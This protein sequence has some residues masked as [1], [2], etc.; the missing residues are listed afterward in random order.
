MGNKLYL[1]Y[2]KLINRGPRV[3]GRK[4]WPS[5]HKDEIR[6]GKGVVDQANL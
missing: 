6:I 4:T 5:A 3:T 2:H 1:I